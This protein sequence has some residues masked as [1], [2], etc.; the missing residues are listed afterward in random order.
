[1]SDVISKFLAKLSKSEK[2]VIK[3]ILEKITTNN[4]VGLQIKKLVGSEDIYRVR[5]GKF[6]IIYRKT[7]TD[8]LIISVD[9]RSEA[10]YRNF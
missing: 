4:T 8:C 10:T 7:K 5:K 9:R 3:N 2:A 6:R 1:M